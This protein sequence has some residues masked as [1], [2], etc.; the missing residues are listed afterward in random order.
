MMAIDAKETRERDALLSELH[1]RLDNMSAADLRAFA[2]AH[3]R[4][5][6]DILAFAAAWLAAPNMTEA[7]D[8]EAQSTFAAEALLERFWAAQPDAVADPFATQDPARLNQIATE[9][10]I[11]AGILRKLERRLIDQA[12][13]PGKLVGWL[14]HALGCDS[15]DLFVYLSL[16]PAAAGADYFAPSGPRTPGKVSFA[17]AVRAS[18]LTDAQKA[19]WL[20]EAAR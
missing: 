12:S 18:S 13:I 5:R 17:D 14:S 3:D 15:G 1:E 7:P 4:F 16:A 10:R 19:L 9:C 11:D 20:P 2:D 8:A 6:D